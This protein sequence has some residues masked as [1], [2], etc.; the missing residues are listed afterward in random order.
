MISLEGRKGE[1][2]GLNPGLKIET[3]GTPALP[4]NA[5][6]PQKEHLAQELAASDC[7]MRCH[8]ERSEGSALKI[9]LAARPKVVILSAAKDL[10]LH[11][12]VFGWNGVP[13]QTAVV[14]GHSG[15][16]PSCPQITRNDPTE[17]IQ[18]PYFY[19]FPVMCIV[20]G[21]E[22]TVTKDRSSC[23][24]EVALELSQGGSDAG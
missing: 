3:W 14:F 22:E 15:G 21:I 16:I 9:A 13:C 10:L 5:V 7:Q 12:H 23:E 6:M 20:T 11:F 4:I 18:R 19:G 24:S 2:I 8:P 1:R 17:G